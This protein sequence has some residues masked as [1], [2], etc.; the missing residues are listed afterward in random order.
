MM[1]SLSVLGW[2]L[3][4][5]AVFSFWPALLASPIIFFGRLRPMA[6]LGTEPHSCCP[7]GHGS[8][9]TLSTEEAA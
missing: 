7:S 5:W 6:I 4:L 3:C 8:S 2:L 9:A 1:E